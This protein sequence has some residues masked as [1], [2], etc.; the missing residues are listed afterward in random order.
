MGGT[1]PHLP[2]LGLPASISPI[3]A[4]EIYCRTKLWQV[5]G[6]LWTKLAIFEAP[7]CTKTNFFRGAL[8]GSFQHSPR[9]LDGFRGGV[10][11][12]FKDP[13]LPFSI[14]P[15]L[16]FFVAMSFCHYCNIVTR[17]HAAEDEHSA[18]MWAIHHKH[19]HTLY[20]HLTLTY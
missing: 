8:L 9:V 19:G 1:Q 13:Y 15:A 2:W 7:K 17:P 16:G 5:N 20:A 10:T 6:V 3:I 18:V 12:P 4:N 14:V 11:A